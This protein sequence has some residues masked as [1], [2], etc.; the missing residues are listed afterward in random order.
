MR[1]IGNTLVDKMVVHW[2]QMDD[3]L[4]RRFDIGGE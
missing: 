1:K 3:G 2:F 4:I